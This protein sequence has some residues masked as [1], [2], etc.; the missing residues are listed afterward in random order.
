MA[1]GGRAD[2]TMAGYAFA[3]DA[4]GGCD[5]WPPGFVGL[6]RGRVAAT[7][8][9]TLETVDDL[10]D[11]VVWVESV[12]VAINEAVICHWGRRLVGLRSSRE[13]FADKTIPAFGRID[14]PSLFATAVQMRA[15]DRKAQVA[16]P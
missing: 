4:T 6:L 8:T 7:A 11:C 2:G 5:S 3:E 15:R 9:V 12:V 14:V 16:E 13:T 1:F 10:V